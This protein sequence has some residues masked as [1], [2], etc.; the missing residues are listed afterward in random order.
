MIST[1]CILEPNEDI[2]SRGKPMD[3]NEKNIQR[4]FISAETR[5]QTLV[6]KRAVLPVLNPL[7][8]RFLNRE[9]ES[10]TKGPLL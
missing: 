7:Q 2:L 10:G 5:L 1:N 9:H 3:M 6:E 8:S 4:K